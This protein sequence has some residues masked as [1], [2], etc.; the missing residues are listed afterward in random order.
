M[1][2][3]RFWWLSFELV[4]VGACDFDLCLSSD[5]LD[6]VMSVFTLSVLRVTSSFRRSFVRLDGCD[7]AEVVLSPFF[8]CDVT[9]NVMAGVRSDLC[10]S[11]CFSLLVLCDFSFIRSWVE[12]E[13]RDDDDDVTFLRLSECDSCDVASRSVFELLTLL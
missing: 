13:G 12:C 11:L 8:T 7:D 2:S 3:V 4:E 10:L 5:E 9:S 1:T 6:D